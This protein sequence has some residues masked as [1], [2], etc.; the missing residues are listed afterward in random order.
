MSAVWTFRSFSII[1]FEYWLVQPLGTVAFV[2]IGATDDSPVETET[3]LRACQCL[4]EMRVL[5]PLATDAMCGIRAG[6]HRQVRQ[7]R[8]AVPSS[9]SSAAALV[10]RYFDG[11]RHRHDGLMNYSVAA[12]LPDATGIVAAK[13]GQEVRLLELLRMVDDMQ[14]D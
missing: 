9:S 1:R 8:N 10:D 4:H 11:L 14:I 5:L 12:V 13:K 6:L 3:L 7:G 2:V